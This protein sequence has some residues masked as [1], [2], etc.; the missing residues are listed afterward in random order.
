MAKSPLKAKNSAAGASLDEGEIRHFSKD[1]SHWWDE[2]GPFKPLHRM[3]PARLSYIREQVLGHFALP[4]NNRYPMTGLKI[5]DIGCGGG[6]IC[7]PLA[8]LGAS[9]TGID[10]DDNAV[11]VA[12]EHAQ[13]M[14]L[15]I[16]YR[17][18]TAE[19]M[20]VKA[21]G[22]FDAVLAL[23]IVEHVADIPSFMKSCAALCR[24]GGIVIFSTLN[25]TPK[26]YV[27]GVVAA[28]NILRWVP[29]GTHDWQKFLKP[30][31]LSSYAADAGLNP[32]SV[33]G[34]VFNPLN[35]NFELS[36]KDLS[37]NYFLTTRKS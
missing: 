25:R 16:S 29:R 18:A 27:L 20:A 24:P 1:S 10:A 37:I 33:R 7:E 2:E 17:S 19:N 21:A 30:S 26:S 11:R 14:S 6:L 32:A 9:V 31:E 15:E 3:N 28:E 22:S 12:S 8:R 34:C 4:A 35:G 5:L 36:Q 13:K 23:E